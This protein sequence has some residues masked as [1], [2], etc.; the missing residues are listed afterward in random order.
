MIDPECSS[1]HG[2]Y[3][4]ICKYR[5]FPFFRASLDEKGRDPEFFL[6]AIRQLGKLFDFD[7]SEP[8]DY[9]G[10]GGIFEEVDQNFNI[11]AK[12]REVSVCLNLHGK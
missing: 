3:R 5:S 2:I 7:A 1:D 11:S 9:A 12:I 8:Y 10:F 4:E 6:K